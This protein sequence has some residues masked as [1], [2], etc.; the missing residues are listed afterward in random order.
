MLTIA[1]IF[2][3]LAVIINPKILFEINIIESFFSFFNITNYDSL[4]LPITILFC[5][6]AI[7]SSLFRMLLY[8][9]QISITQNIS[10]TIKQVIYKKILFQPYKFHFENNSS[11]LIAV[12]LAKAQETSS[13]VVL[14]FL[15]IISSFLIITFIFILLV[16]INPILTLSSLIFLLIIYSLI[17]YFGKR[18]LSRNSKIY[19]LAETQIVKAMQEGI[20]G[21]RDVILNGLENYYIR[22]L[23]KNN[24]NLKKS[25]LRISLIGFA[26]RYI[27]EGIGLCTIAV[28]AYL[29][30]ANDLKTDYLIPTLGTLAL[31]AQRMLPLMQQAF[32]SWS[33]I[34][35]HTARLDDVLKFLNLEISST[36][37]IDSK[38]CIDFKDH[39][40]LKNIY[41]SYDKED[42]KIIDNL[43]YKINKGDK[44]GILGK[45]GSGKT[46][47]I[48]ILMGLLDPEKGNIYIDN[49]AIN[50]SN[51]KNWRANIAHVPQNIYLSDN[52]IAE[53]IAVG[54]P[55]N[56]INY[57]L[58]IEV[59]R[60][61]QILDLIKDM[62]Y[63][64]DTN[65]GER[66]VKLSGGQ[67][68]RIGIARAL[69]KSASIIILDEATSALDVNTEKSIMKIIDDLSKDLTIIIIAHRFSSLKYCDK[70]IELKEGRIV[71][72][73]SY[74]DLKNK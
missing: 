50:K 67:L 58:L 28:I 25:S 19:S 62:K 51:V 52:T 2:P 65:V 43:T 38:E 23:Y 37:L 60:K 21:I 27:I 3:F 10:V 15:N 53:N 56:E 48:N 12:I 54:I 74:N 30:V 40:L 71:N 72:T 66:G 41:F 22:L 29:S 1:A 49:S 36:K 68:Q 9:L 47:L 64:F 18:I 55:K 42:T 13:K 33:D 69:Y 17:I 24:I 32:K 14:P 11:D 5:L 8:Y 61:A 46:T 59:A 16:L 20:G 63:K 45:T 39:I 4:L 26:P 31:G 35:G 44:I 6:S 70:I 7:I 57:A 34:K 73:Y